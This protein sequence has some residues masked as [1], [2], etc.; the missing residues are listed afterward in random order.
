MLRYASPLSLLLLG[1]CQLLPSPLQVYDM[2]PDSSLH[3]FDFD[4]FRS[5]EP[6]FVVVG[7]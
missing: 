1:F 6:V 2:L 5:S 3:L 4:D 7:W